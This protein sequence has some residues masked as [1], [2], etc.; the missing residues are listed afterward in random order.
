MSLV[1]DLALMK[2]RAATAAVFLGLFAS[3]CGTAS[4]DSGVAE[5]AATTPACSPGALG[6]TMTASPTAVSVVAAGAQPT[7]GEVSTLSIKYTNNSCET[8]SGLTLSITPY[9]NGPTAGDSGVTFDTSR[10]V[11]AQGTASIFDLPDL[12]TGQ[13]ATAT[14]QVDYTTAGSKTVSGLIQSGNGTHASVGPVSI[15]AS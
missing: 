2:A 6:A 3:A 10:S 5:S 13:S 8:L 4:T 12:A 14:I 11:A 7:S 15:T 1:Y 9:Q